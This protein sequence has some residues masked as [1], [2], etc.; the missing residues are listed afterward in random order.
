MLERQRTQS[1]TP[2]SGLLPLSSTIFRYEF[3]FDIYRC[4]LGR[5]TG[6]FGPGTDFTN[7][8]IWSISLLDAVVAA[9]AN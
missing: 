6:G 7:R 8:P 4:V 9:G 1:T 5:A 3:D 2:V